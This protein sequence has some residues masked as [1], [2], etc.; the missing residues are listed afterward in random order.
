VLLILRRRRSRCIRNRQHK[1][2]WH[3][4]ERLL[5]SIGD[6]FSVFADQLYLLYVDCS[7]VAIFL[8]LRICGLGLNQFVGTEI[9]NE[10]IPF[11]SFYR[12]PQGNVRG[13]EDG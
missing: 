3:G 5:G 2:T 13:I 1:Q 7:P 4:S 11:L 9:S 8:A 12:Q 6:L 10:D